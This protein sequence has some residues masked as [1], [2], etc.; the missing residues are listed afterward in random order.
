M[1]VTLNG[2]SDAFEDVL[3]V[4]VLT[5]AETV[6]AYGNVP[7]SVGAPAPGRPAAGA[8]AATQA[9]ETLEIPNDVTPTAG[10]LHFELASTAMVGLSGGA[11]YLVDYPYG[12]AEQRSSAAMA[13]ML[14][15]DLGEAFALP[16]IDA[17]G[18][19]ADR[20]QEK[21]HANRLIVS[22]QRQCE[23][24][25]GWLLKMQ[26][27]EQSLGLITGRGYQRLPFLG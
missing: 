13:L 27:L 21:Q 17:K 25:A 24:T 2:E 20:A 9:Q 4:R 3:P 18:A 14:A 8:A 5:P 6:A 15:S 23:H 22:D 1:S 26:C 10:G 16:G 11:Q 12:C 19:R 7:P